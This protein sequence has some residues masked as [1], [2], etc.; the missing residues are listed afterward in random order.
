MDRKLKR[1][2]FIKLSSV[3]VIGTV[4]AA[5][6]PQVTPPPAEPTKAP[7]A[8]K[9]ADTVAAPAAAPTNTTAPEA[10]NP[11]EPPPKTAGFKQAPLFD[12]RVK[13]GALP[14]VEERLPAQPYVTANREAV[15]VYG[16]EMRLSMMDP[17]W[18]VS[19]YDILVERCLIYSDQDGKT[20]VPNVLES[21]EVTPDG[22]TYTFK[23]RKGM[24]WNSG[25]PITTE[26]VRFWWEDHMTY[27]DINSSPWWQFRFGGANM[28]VKII[29]DF[30]FS[31]TFAVP[32][33]NFAA[34]LTRWT[35]GG[36]CIIFPSK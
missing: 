14:P 9:P 11:T 16:G 23:L 15:G 2:D 20:I 26:D 31:F 34:H 17:V 35:P 6:A 3:A 28:T 25:D 13:S 22:K 29:D 1:R 24:K 30:S 32:F 8:P 18:W 27:K 19:A 7:E 21:W 4:A 33:G 10:P 12:D 36:D 5:C